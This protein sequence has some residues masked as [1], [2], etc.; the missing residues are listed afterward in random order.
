MGTSNTLSNKNIQYN[1]F[2]RGS[3]LNVSL[4]SATIVFGN[5]EKTIYK[6]SDG[7][8]KIRYFN[9]NDVLIIADITD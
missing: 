1:N 4:S 3:I 2:I 9:D 7:T 5:F 6:R 8:T